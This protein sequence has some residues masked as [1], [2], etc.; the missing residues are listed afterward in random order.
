MLLQ[1]RLILLHFCW[2]FCEKVIVGGKCFWSIFKI[3]LSMVNNIYWV[4]RIKPHSFTFLCTLVVDLCVSRW[5]FNTDQIINTTSR[6]LCKYWLYLQRL[7][8]LVMFGMWLLI[9][10]RICF[11][12]LLTL[13]YS[14]RTSKKYL[15]TIQKIL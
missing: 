13:I 11:L 2:I 14:T 15:S 8:C 9:D 4:K 6:Y 7:L 5:F 3:I 10:F 1:L 12:M